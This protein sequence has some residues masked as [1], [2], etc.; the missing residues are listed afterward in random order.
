[1]KNV[2]DYLQNLLQRCPERLAAADREHS[3]TFRQLSHTA[4]CMASAIPDSLHNQSIGVFTDRSADAVMLCLAVLYSGNYYIPIDP[5]LPGQ[6]LQSILDDAQPQVLLGSEQTRSL[7]D[8]VR[9]HGIYLTCEN[10]ADS[11]RALPDNGGE[12]PLYMIYTSGSTGKPK[13]VLKSHAAEISFLEAYC[14]AFGFTGEEIIGNQTPFFFDAAGKDLYLMLK[15]G[16]T[17]EIIPT[18]LFSMPPML[19]EY[20]NERRI[21]FIS[22]VPTALS[23]VAQLRT[24]SFIKPDSLRRVFFVGEVM[25]MKHLNYWR[26]ALPEV[27]YVN[28]YGSTEI[29]GICAA[30]EVT[31]EFGDDASLPMGKPLGNCRIYLLDGEHTVTEPDTVGEL[32][33]VSPALATEYYHDPEKT[34][35][36]FL[37]KDFGDGLA[38][39]FKTGD[40]ARYDREGNLVFAARS[41]YQIKHMG[42]RIELGEIEAVAGALPGVARCCCLYHSAKS[43]IVLFCQCAEEAR[44]LTG[45]EIRHLLRGRLSSYMLPAKVHVL[46]ALPLNANGK[47]DR[48]ALQATLD[49]DK[50]NKGE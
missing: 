6:K 10:M 22:W 7:L 28:L 50:K 30:Y 19:I 25:P 33:L 5:E 23:I 16:A 36:S 37:Y 34:A 48:R 15:T 3:Y 4:R 42:H 11:P 8:S 45:K 39:C 43:H 21:S 38:R 1:M 14:D 31:G 29:A 12:D 35:A 2:L 24:F 44:E 18:E 13:G 26:R 9:Y 46:D 41:D 27:Q 47:I 32:Y 40:L 17:M 20:L 49:K